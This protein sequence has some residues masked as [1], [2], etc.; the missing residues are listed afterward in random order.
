ME[1]LNH[2]IRLKNE[3]SNAKYK[4]QADK[5]RMFQ[6]FQEENM[7]M[8]Y[9]PKKKKGKGKEKETPSWLLFQPR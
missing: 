7:L 4:K 3:E 6:N 9:L 8:V 1:K 2:E 5:T